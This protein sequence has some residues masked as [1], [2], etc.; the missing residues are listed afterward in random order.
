MS[1]SEKIEILKQK[2]V[3]FPSPLCVEIGEEV[4]PDR[5]QAECTIYGGSKIYSRDTFICRGAQIGYESPATLENCCVGPDVRLGGGF[6]K[7]AVFLKGAKT[8]PNAHVREGTILEESAGIAHCVG[9]KQ[10]ILFP[11]VTLGSLINFCDCLMAGGT[12]PKNHS[13]V[14]SSYIHFNFTPLQDKATPSLL[15]NVPEGVMLNNEPIF[16]GGQGGLVGPCRIAFGTVIAAGT[17][18]RRDETRPGRLIF[19]APARQGNISRAA[20]GPGNVKRVLFNN[21]VYIGNL[22]AL[23][24]WYSYIRILFISDDFPKPLFRG[25]CN[26]LKNALDERFRR[27]SEYVDKIRS[28]GH[29]N[30]LIDS[31]ETVLSTLENPEDSSHTSILGN[32]FINIMK[33]KIE[34]NGYDY[35]STI[36]ALSENEA[37]TGTE[38]LNMIVRDTCDCAI[39]MLGPEPGWE[40]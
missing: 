2:G 39:H 5:I 12:G 21:I 34:S 13:E 6:Y 4:E 18:C 16:L 30:A 36:G 15:G 19:G 9:L 35:L 20:L 11:Y 29:K 38:W 40:I 8:G 27:L 3:C 24:Q 28:S 10:T 22:R 7:S 26:T 32:R 1:S 33:E 17:I 31:W 25:A 37:R 14:G 23:F